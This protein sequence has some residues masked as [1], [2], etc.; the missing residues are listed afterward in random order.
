MLWYPTLSKHG[1][2]SIIGDTDQASTGKW[3]V[4]I[5]V[6]DIGQLWEEIED[7]AV[8]GKLLA[9]KK[10]TQLLKKQIGHDLVCV[11]CSSSDE[12]T[13]AETLAILRE[14]GID[15]D[16]RYKSDLATFKW[17]DEYLYSSNDFEGPQLK[18]F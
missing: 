3:L 1:F 12:A 16:L 6:P 9:V 5:Q 17:R 2:R 8:E 7:A 15:G 13:V 4:S 14:I 18:P 10:S 11:Y